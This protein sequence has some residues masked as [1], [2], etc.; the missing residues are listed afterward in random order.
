MVGG[1]ITPANQTICSGQT[2]TILQVVGGSTGLAI[3]YQW[4]ESPDGILFTDIASA[5]SQDFTPPQLNVTRFYR[6]LVNAAGGGP[7]AS[8]TE[9]SSV[10]RIEVIDIDPGALDPSQ[11]QD[12]CYGAMPPSIISSTTLGIPDDA[13]SS[14]GTITY[15]WQMRTNTSSWTYIAS[16]TN[17]F[18]NPPSLNETTWFRRIARASITSA[19]FCE[20]TSNEIRIGI[21]PDLNEGFVLAD[22]VICQIITAFDLPTNPLVLNGAETLTNS[23]TYQ[24]QQSQ[25]QYNWTDITGQQSE[26]LTF[27]LG[28]A[29]LPTVPATYYRGIITYVGDPAPSALE[30]TII[31]FVDEGTPIAGGLTYTI[32]INGIAY[33]VTSSAS[34]TIDSIAQDLANEITIN[35]FVV[36]ATYNASINMMTII[37]VVAGD[38]D[39]ASSQTPADP[40]I[41]FV[42]PDTGREL[43]MR[44]LVTG[45]T[46]GRLPNNNRD[47]CQAYTEVVTIE[48]LPQP[49][50]VQVSGDPGPQEVCIGD[51]IDPIT[52]AY[53]G[54]ASS[55]E[56]RDIS[57]TLTIT[58]P[59]ATITN[60][61]P[62]WYELSGTNTFTISGSV[63]GPNTISFVTL[64]S[65]CT[66]I[67]ETYQIRV[68]SNAVTPSFIRMDVD[69][70]GYEVLE[71]PAIAGV[72]FNNTVCQDNLPA[73]TTPS[74]EF[75]ACFVNDALARQ[76][77]T[78]E[79]NFS[80]PTAGVM[81][82]NNFQETIVGIVDVGSGPSV[83]VTYTLTL[84]ASATTNTYTFVTTAASQTADI[85]GLQL[86]NQVN[87]SPSV[88]AIY[89]NTSD[90]IIVESLFA[91]TAFTVTATPT[92]TGQNL[93]LLAP[94]TRQIVRS[95]TMNWDPSFSGRA[96]I[97]VRSVGCD[98]PS[99]W[100]DVAIDVVPQTV[101]PTPTTSDLLEPDAYNFEICGGEFT[102]EIPDCQIINTTPD[103]QF[104]TASDNGAN[105]NEFDRLEWQVSNP[106]PGAGSLVNNP[107]TIDQDTGTMSWSVGWW[108]SFELQV[109]PISCSGIA[110]DW[111]SRTIYIGPQ[112]GPITSVTPVG[113]DPLP[114]CPIP[115]GGFSTT[116]TTGGAAVRWFVNS[117]AGLAATTTFVASNTFFELPP[118][119]ANSDTVELNFRPGFSGNII[120]SA[121]PT[122]CPGERVNY[123][124]SIPGR[125]QIN[126]TSGFNSNNQIRCNNTALNTITYEIEGAADLVTAVGLPN[127]VNFNIVITSQQTSISIATVSS[128]QAN[129]NYSLSINNTRYDFTTTGVFA[130]AAQH[131]G[132]GLASAV[133]SATTDFVATYTAGN[134]LIEVGPTGQPGNSFILATTSPINSSVN[135]GAPVSE[136]LS[137][138]VN[139]FGTPSITGTGLFT[140]NLITQAPQP[141]CETRTTTG[142][143]QILEDAS[144]SVVQGTALNTGV[145]GVSDFNGLNAIIMEF[146]GTTG[147]IQLSPTSPNALPNG[148]FLNPVGGVFNQY[149]ISGNMNQVVTTTTQWDVDFETFG[150]SCDE[151]TQRITFM[152]EPSPIASLT[153]TASLGTDRSVCSSETMVPIRFEIANPAF[154]LTTTGTSAFPNGVTGQSYAQNQITRVRV[155]QDGGP[156]LTTNI[157][158]T[159]TV[160]INGTPYIAEVGDELPS[161]THN[162]PQLVGELSTYLSA[163]LSPTFTVRDANPFIEF[164]A[165]TAGV[166][167]TVSALASSHLVFDPPTTTQP[168]AY[169]EISGTPTPVT[170]Q[171][172]FVYLLQSV[173]A[174]GDCSGSFV[175]SGTITVRPT[176][177]AFVS[178][179]N[180][181]AGQNPVFCDIGV[182][183]STLYQTVGGVLTVNRD[184]ITPAWITATLDPVL[185]EVTVDFT[186]PVIG[187]TSVQTFTYRFNLFG[188]GFGCTATPAPITG[189]VSISP[190]DQITFN[191]AAGDDAQ[192]VCVNNAA[193]LPSFRPIEYLLSGGATTVNTITYRQDGGAIQSGLPPGFW[194]YCCWKRRTNYWYGDRCCCFSNCPSNHL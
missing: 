179:L 118:T 163:Q 164:E 130:N 156:I 184:V 44:I 125:P 20:E 78:Y 108:G 73:P 83:G 72:W 37:P 193:I 13:T 10:T 2:P 144:I 166:A 121:E 93:R 62:N 124:I 46:G 32:S 145:C 71:H 17:N 84:I 89:N 154:T 138:V 107:G 176:T 28:D 74:S 94:A 141:G 19:T 15:R 99:D 119:N 29:W 82:Q 170:T 87:T 23:V 3:T 114:L 189:I 131:I 167:F 128:T 181:G 103:T 162:I 188:N 192:T 115:A 101:V 47:S 185:G 4:Q 30:Q 120:V 70:Q 148:L 26:T 42:L 95:G 169:Y 6:R 11:N 171:T 106:Q 50:F 136:P 79:W 85:V 45:N 5:T 104:F 59:G 100:L 61:Q 186:P 65:G 112:D 12:Y 194:L 152:I 147:G 155:I 137:K 150:A 69:A 16:A 49:T 110:G 149:S 126:L 191:G 48:V 43:N 135:F 134:I 180:P 22:D 102:G 18:Y 9:V 64:G 57:T 151:A 140:Y 34:S 40:G 127:G 53:G 66:E 142:T 36:N 31:E 51:P 175:A 105:P 143:I 39:V 132:Q 56:I 159:F 160:N 81:V 67:T 77:N 60:T 63:G 123:V 68:L 158:D 54:G 24:W 80:P 117:P 92:G 139:I 177:S 174:G 129:R 172:D 27:N 187:V 41:A 86:A 122:P 165:N 33:N 38:F 8:C 157:S 146:A 109:R 178:P 90:E 1:S 14:A 153:S 97:R 35:D 183:S 88:R 98:G 116:L 190:Q 173:G 55:I 161:F 133:N 76:F 52:F 75:F 25:D 91:N 96:T 111:K 182:V 58:A 7:P 168:P 21:L 113:A